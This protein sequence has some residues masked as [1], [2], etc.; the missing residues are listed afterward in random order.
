MILFSFSGCEDKEKKALQDVTIVQQQENT[1]L[2]KELQAKEVALKQARQ[3][4]K[5]AN[6]KLLAQEKEKKEA[7]I[8]EQE[9]KAKQSVQN[10][11]LSQMGIC[12]N[13]SKISIDTN[14]TKDFFTNIGNTLGDKLNKIAKGIEK[15]DIDDNSTGVK[16]NK[17]HINI[18][19]NKTKNFL[20]T[21]G[22]KMQGFVKEFDTITK[23]LTLEPK[24]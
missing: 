9:R 19:L 1:K 6:E 7:F 21:W 24:K 13:D 8:E 16:I 17:D 5:I 15:G 22:K 20:E 12:V 3:E 14:V 2:L 23:E 11:K 18:D 4:A 10:Q